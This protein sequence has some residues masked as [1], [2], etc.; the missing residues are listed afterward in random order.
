[1]REATGD[2]LGHLLGEVPETVEIP[3]ELWC[4]LVK[5]LN[6]AEYKNKVKPFLD[7]LAEGKKPRNYLAEAEQ[8]MR[9]EGKLEML[10]K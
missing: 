8:R 6:P 3:F 1:M 5:Q 4:E 10:R 2:A 7:K 9:D